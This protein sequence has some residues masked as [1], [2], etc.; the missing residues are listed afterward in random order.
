MS[1]NAKLNVIK[2]NM[3]VG[4]GAIALLVSAF[5]LDPTQ[6]PQQQIV[7]AP[8]IIDEISSDSATVYTEDDRFT[9]KVEFDSRTFGDGNSYQTWNDVE[10]NQIKDIK[11]YGDHGEV[12]DYY[13]DQVDV[14][15]LAN[16]LEKELRDRL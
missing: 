4:T 8:F 9:L 3:L 5:V 2:S 6:E 11:V 7:T 15:I 10:L 12:A 14:S 13:L 1:M 16:Q